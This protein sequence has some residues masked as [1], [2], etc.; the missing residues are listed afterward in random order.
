MKIQLKRSNI[1]EAGGGAKEPTEGQM[2]YGE[3]AVNYSSEDPAIF[4]KDADNN[5]IRIAGQGSLGEFSGSYLDLTNTPTIGDGN[6]TITS[7][8]IQRGSFSVNQTGDVTI[9]LPVNTGPQGPQGEEGPQGLIGPPG[10]QGD[11]GPQ[12]NPGGAGTPGAKGDTGERGLTGPPGPQGGK[13]DTGTPGPQGPEGPKGDT[14][15][16]GN[17]GPAGSPSTTAGP[18]GPPGPPGANGTPGAGGQPGPQGKT[19][20]PGPPGGQGGTGNPGGQ[21]PPGPPGTPYW[22]LSGSNLYP[23]STSYNVPIGRTSASERLHVNGKVLATGFRIDQ[24]T[25]LT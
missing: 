12:G 25:E 18:Q 14:G 10:P 8:G 1:V 11:A 21:G 17:T 9:D 24:L 3:L 20:P 4:M 23:N 6:I 16:P 22:S 2:E 13:G 5:V 7:G 15:N 19:G